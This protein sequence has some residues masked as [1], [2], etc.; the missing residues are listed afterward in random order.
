MAGQLLRARRREGAGAPASAA[1]LGHA[2]EGDARLEAAIKRFELW[3]SMV[4]NERH[5]RRPGT[6]SARST[7]WT[8]SSA[9]CSSAARWRSSCASPS[10]EDNGSSLRETDD[11]RRSSAAGCDVRRLPPRAPGGR[12]RTVPQ[13]RA[14]EDPRRRARGDFGGTLVGPS[15][16]IGYLE[17]ASRAKTP[18]SR[19]SRPSG[20]RG[21]CMRSEA[22]ALLASSCSATTRCGRR[23][24]RSGGERTRLELCLLMLSVRTAS[25]STSR[26]TTSTSRAWRCW[27]AVG[28][29]DGTAS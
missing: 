5:I 7:A 23:S 19:R 6:S 4:V 10:E 26:R 29:F 8:R 12:G 18:R 27:R 1:G 15:V 13:D 28:S 20:R 22:V 24:V 14:R 2:A 3:A 11:V 9:R 17:Q 25:C 16:R 21:R